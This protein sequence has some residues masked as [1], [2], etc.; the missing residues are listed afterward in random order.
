MK[1]EIIT[2]F[3]GI[4][5]GFLKESLVGKAVSSG[6]LQITL[7]N[8]RDFAPPPHRS[9]DD[10]PYGGGPGMVLKPEPLADAVKSAKK[11][12]PAAK[13]VLL[14][15]SGEPFKQGLARSFAAESA[16]L[17]LV[18]GRYEG[19]DQRFIDLYVDKEI[20]IGDYVLMGGEVP[21]M[22]LIESITRL[23]PGV[24]GNESSTELESYENNLLEAPQY[25]RPPEFENM[26]VPQPLLS[27]DHKA[28]T[29]W[30]KERSLELTS[31]RRPDLIAKTKE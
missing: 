30:R 18:C 29:N 23:I 19:V 26:K 1:L 5:A 4:F 24:I 3:P 7:T 6:S 31:R 21:A 8:F 16:E 2:I 10:S 27:G 9:V 25:T 15:A 22:V 12:L 14:S 13:V 11:R 17:I 20:S 28:I